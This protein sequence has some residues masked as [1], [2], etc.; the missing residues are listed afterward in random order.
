M[1]IALHAGFLWKH[2]GMVVALAITG[3][4]IWYPYEF[5]SFEGKKKNFRSA[6]EL[7]EKMLPWLRE[8]LIGW[9][10][11]GM[12]HYHQDGNRYLFVAMTRDDRCIVEEGLDDEALWN[13]LCEKATAEV[14][15][16]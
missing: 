1:N 7:T 4:G 13:R 9:S 15:T 2:I 16:R 5:L 12:N 6:P 14:R 10:I 3:M 11:V 8:P